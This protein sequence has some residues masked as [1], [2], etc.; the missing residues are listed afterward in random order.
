MAKKKKRIPKEDRLIE[1]EV[2]KAA[3]AYLEHYY[4]TQERPK[5]LYSNLE[6]R[7][8]HKYGMKR[9]DGLLAYPM[10]KTKAYVVSMEAKSHKTLKALK[11][12]RIDKLWVKDSLWHGLLFTI[13]SGVMFFVWRMTDESF[14][15][16]FMI[17]LGVFLGASALYAYI[18]RNSHKYQEM[19]VIHQVFQ[20][21]A[22]EQW[23]SLSNDSFE[24]IDFR[25]QDNLIKICKARGV[26]VLMVDPKKNVAMV[27]APQKRPK[28]WF[29]DYLHFYHA[30][31]AIRKQLGLKMPTK[32]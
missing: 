31:E 6:E 14:W 11:P 26:G 1:L 29:G 20:Y 28:R 15:I 4:K 8:K 19:K 16:R 3:Q 10:S 13:L 18:F 7:T 17:P 2:Q 23:L 30:E 22:N 25:L 9:A 5:A 32:K 24:M 12:Y 21:P 27:H